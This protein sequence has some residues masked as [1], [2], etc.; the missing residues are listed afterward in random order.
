MTTRAATD[1]AAARISLSISGEAG[2][3][4]IILFKSHDREAH[5]R[6]L[7]RLSR[8][9]LRRKGCDSP[10]SFGLGLGN[11]PS[12]NFERNNIVR[13]ST[14]INDVLYGSVLLATVDSPSLEN[15]EGANL[16]ADWDIVVA[17]HRFLSLPLG[18][19]RYRRRVI[20]KTKQSA[21]SQGYNTIGLPLVGSNQKV[22][23]A[24]T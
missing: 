2:I 21:R 22:W 20:A 15:R 10:A 14:E 3:P 11:P 13:S 18:R 7:D 23:G 12:I 17:A 1:H 24:F 4:P 8:E 16:Q 6:K 19:N 9:L 5:Y